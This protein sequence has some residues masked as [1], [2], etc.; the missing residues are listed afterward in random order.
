MLLF[1]A[2]MTS[3]LTVN[4]Q[5]CPP[6]AGIFETCDLT[7]VPEVSA[8]VE[9]YS[10]NK[11]FLVP[12]MTEAQKLAIVTP[13]TGLLVF[14]T[15]GASGFSYYNGTS[16]DLIEST[17]TDWIISGNDMS[18]AISGNVGI[19]TASPMFKVD[20]LGTGGTR[21]RTFSQDNLWAGYLSKNNTREFFAGTQGTIETP[22]TTSGYHIYDNTA[23][24]QRM[25]ID[26][27]GNMG[28]NNNNPTA[29]LDVAGTFKLVDGTE[30]AG[31]VLTSDASGNAIWATSTSTDNQD[32]TLSGNSLSLTNDATPVDL[33]AF[34]DNTDAQS[35][36]LSG[37]DL[38]IS[39][40]N[41]I[42]LAGLSGGAFATTTNLTSNSPGTIA[43]DDFVFG[44]TT[45]EYVTEN[46]YI[47]FDKS[48]GAFRAGGN[49]GEWN[50]ANRGNN[51]FASGYRTL[52]SGQ[53]S[54]SMGLFSKVYG[55]S[56]AAIGN[57]VS[58]HSYGEVSVGVFNTIYTPNSA[59]A[60]NVA[61]RVFVVGNGQHGGARSNAFTVFKNGNAT[62]AGTLT[63]SSDKRLKT[64]ISTLTGSLANLLQ[65]GGYSYNWIDTEKRGTDKQIGVIA[66]EVEALYPE[67]VRKD[68]NGNLSVNYS[69][70]VPILIEAT[71]EQQAEIEVLK[72]QVQEMNQ[73]KTEISEI[74]AMLE[75][76][77]SK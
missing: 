10:T 54:T 3:H 39:N 57:D 6:N 32:L 52:A 28:I 36:T 50:D 60:W 73:L 69:G 1:V 77:A 14:Q 16:W 21:T 41:T 55:A 66:Q 72:A 65:L 37:T 22:N 59:T 47:L 15:D 71:K 35:L 68:N 11:G 12:R 20:V 42:S 8:M 75:T 56:A 7:A 26:E 53:Y 44:A 31:K 62:L 13:A 48:K 46:N 58:A 18:S 5:N 19:G 67:L 45:T 17:N 51:S 4:G 43:T 30:G 2:L 27:N 25:V 23:G 24:A 64:N 49:V 34:L 33:S 38:S 63:Q 40:G 29:R 76:K 74:K 61:D 9:L 70:L